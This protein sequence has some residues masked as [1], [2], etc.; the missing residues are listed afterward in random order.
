[1]ATKYFLGTATAVAQV[2]T[3]QVTGYDA[4]TTYKITVA[5][6]DI[7]SELGVT[8]ADGTASAISSAWNASTNPL[9]TQVTASVATDTVTFTADN[10]GEPFTL[11]SS[12]TGGSGTIGAASTSTASSGP[13]DWSTA[14]NWSDGSVPVDT[15]T[16]IIAGISTPICWGLDQNT[17]DLTELIVEQTYTG[18]LGL[19]LNVLATAAD[20]STSSSAKNE[21]REDYLKISATTVRLGQHLGPGS[22]GGSSRI[23]IDNTKAGASDTIVYDTASASSETGKPSVRLKVAHASSELFV[24]E[25]PGG[26]GVAVDEP[27]ETSTLALVSV[28][29]RTTQAGVFVGGGTTLTTWR[30]QGGT[31]VLER[32]TGTLTTCTVTGGT[33]ETLGA[34]TI[35]TLNVTGGT[36]RA[37]HGG[38]GVTTANLSG[39]QVDMTRNTDA[40]TWTTINLEPGASILAG[41]H[42]TFT[43]INEPSGQE[44]YTLTV[45]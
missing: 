21:Y 30:Q 7:V 32:D 8:D 19:D 9:A 28:G 12:V 43:T 23:K 2:T 36:L 24:L 20:A 11:S 13:N 4:A 17:V 22:P 45:S 1:M 34:F 25:A 31:C 35:T 5:G 14:A 3:V 18:K 41:P 40:V 10:A 16:V 6:E 15:D 37:N 29:D 26:V 27:G 33:L 39:G 42:V 38:G 44:T